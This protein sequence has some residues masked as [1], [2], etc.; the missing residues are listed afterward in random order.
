MEKEHTE[1]NHAPVK[2]SDFLGRL[3][4]DKAMKL[5]LPHTELVPKLH[6]QL[7]DYAWFRGVQYSWLA[8]LR[9]REVVGHL[10]PGFLGQL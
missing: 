3:I 5:G 6:L 7:I 10:T 2:L 1:Q 4:L 8:C 9:H